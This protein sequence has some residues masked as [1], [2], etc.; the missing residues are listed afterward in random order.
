MANNHSGMQSP[1]KILYAADCMNFSVP[2]CIHIINKFIY[3]PKYIIHEAIMIFSQW[4][5]KKI[6][7]P[8]KPT[9]L[10]V[11]YFQIDRKPQH[12]RK[13]EYNLNCC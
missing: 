6:Q 11:K 12:L 2:K 8:A 9:V 5:S 1:A 7:Q 13:Q 4:T 10:K 3:I